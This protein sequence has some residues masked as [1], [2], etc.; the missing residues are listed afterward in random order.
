MNNQWVF[1][2]DLAWAKL[3]L[4]LI[5]KNFAYRKFFKKFREYELQLEQHGVW[6]GL[7]F[8]DFGLVGLRY[9]VGHPQY[10]EIRDLCDPLEDINTFPKKLVE[11]VLPRLFY[12]NA[13]SS[14]EVQGQPIKVALEGYR[15]EPIENIARK[16]LAPYERVFKIDLRKK[17][18]Q[19]LKEFER[20]LDEAYFQKGKSKTFD[21]KNKQ[22][23]SWL[24]EKQRYRKE[25]WNHLKVWELRK[26]KKSFSNIAVALRISE[27]R[28]KKAF[29]RAFELTQKKKY[30]PQALRRE[31][32][33][34]RKEEIKKTCDTCP[35]RQNCVT[36][37]PEVLAFV[38]QDTLENSRERLL[39]ND[40]DT[41]KDYCFS[42]NLTE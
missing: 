27:D 34:I 7:E 36:L 31:I 23:Y 18:N 4:A 37:C 9:F 17:K 10:P 26:Q 1:Q 28:A 8:N 16:G 41:F 40:S 32:W 20:Y 19:I 15:S 33:V 22:Y 42:K 2:E 13:V 5:K 38:N 12:Q 29:Y 30:N 14:L 35:E 21:A 3:K 24:A 25:I 11:S 6:P 39:I